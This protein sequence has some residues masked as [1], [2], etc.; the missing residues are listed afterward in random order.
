MS[1]KQ[2][3]MISLT[4]TLLKSAFGIWDYHSRDSAVFGR[5]VSKDLSDFLQ[6]EGKDTDF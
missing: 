3:I 6:L 1:T 4:P 2:N 5:G